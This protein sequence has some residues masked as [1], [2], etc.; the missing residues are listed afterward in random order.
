MDRN[1]GRGRSEA[2]DRNTEVSFVLIAGLILSYSMI[3][4]ALLWLETIGLA[5]YSTF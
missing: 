1:A 2:G 3:C 4:L 5:Y